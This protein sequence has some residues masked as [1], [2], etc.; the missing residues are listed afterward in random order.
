LGGKV[1]DQINTA[2]IKYKRKKYNKLLDLIKYLTNK[3]SKKSTTNL[4]SRVKTV[5]RKYK[6]YCTLLF[7][8]NIVTMLN[9]LLQV[10]PSEIK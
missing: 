10:V 3:P 5:F 8:F 7:L 9:L 1:K 6:D 4:I 2:I